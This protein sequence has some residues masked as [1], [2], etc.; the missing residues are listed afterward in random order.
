MAPIVL[1]LVLALL[2]EVVGTVGGF[3]SSTFFVP[4][5]QIF[6]PFKLVLA[7]TA[8]FHV[9]SNVAKLG[10]FWRDVDHRLALII[11]IPSVIF[12]VIGAYLTRIV[13]TQQ[14]QLVLGI[15]LVAF[16]LLFLL[17]PIKFEADTKQAMV[18]GGVAGFAAGL[19]GTGGAIRGATLV[20]FD[21]RKEVF[22]A[23]SAAIDLAVDLSRSIVYVEG[24]YLSPTHYEYI[25]ALFVVAFMGSWIGKQVL[26][27]ISQEHFRTTVL[28]LIITIGLWLTL[29]TVT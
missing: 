23:T 6:F 9:A 3:G 27:R 1:F 22:V 15:F 7:I 4:I 14:A 20:A 10:L 16:G 17:R 12:V 24:G 18:G 5:A 26:H 8:L 2:A 19:L 13:P 25:P 29:Q 21:L 11:G 28:V